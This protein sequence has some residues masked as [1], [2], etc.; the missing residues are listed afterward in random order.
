LKEGGD[1]YMEI[2]KQMKHDIQGAQVPEHLQQIRE[3]IM[4]NERTEE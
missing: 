4:N 1:D 3:L 2:Q